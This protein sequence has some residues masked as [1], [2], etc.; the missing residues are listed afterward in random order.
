M[1]SLKLISF[2]NTPIVNSESEQADQIRIRAMRFHSQAYKWFINM[3]TVGFAASSESYTLPH[4]Y[5][6]C[7]NAW[8]AQKALNLGAHVVPPWTEPNRTIFSLIIYAKGWIS[9]FGLKVATTKKKSSM[10]ARFLL[11]IHRMSWSFFPPNWTPQM[12]DNM[13]QQMRI[14]WNWAP[15][16]LCPFRV[17]FDCAGVLNSDNIA[18]YNAVELTSVSIISVKLLFKYSNDRFDFA[19]KSTRGLFLASSFF[20]IVEWIRS[21]NICALGQWERANN[22]WN[23]QKYL[24]YFFRRSMR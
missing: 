13:V 3:K 10:A 23:Y 22:L 24:G 17:G 18:E 6:A 1:L 14:C 8:R 9:V 19:L 11:F 21:S 4:P 16:L 12:W 20:F 7:E 15:N 5:T 2:T